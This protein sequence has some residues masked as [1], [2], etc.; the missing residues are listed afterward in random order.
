ME[1][2]NE[3]AAQSDVTALRRSFIALKS[4]SEFSPHLLPRRDVDGIQG[5]QA[6]RGAPSRPAWD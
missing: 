3:G 5:A 1:Q 4:S 2:S 6:R